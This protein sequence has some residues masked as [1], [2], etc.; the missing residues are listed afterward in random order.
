MG[1]T[2]ISITRRRLFMV[3]LGLACALA[4]VLI[5][6]LKATPIPADVDPTFRVRQ[7]YGNGAYIRKEK[8]WQTGEY[9][10]EIRI[11][12]RHPG[13]YIVTQVLNNGNS[14]WQ[15]FEATLEEYAPGYRF[16][17]TDYGEGEEP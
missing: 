6:S 5:G 3:R 17:P 12:A 7:L 1:I 9:V 4:L 2:T 14:I 10:Y 13:G 15:A 11:D 8:H 16:E